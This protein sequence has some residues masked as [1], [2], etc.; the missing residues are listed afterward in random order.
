M[1]VE[2]AFPISSFQT[3][4][5]KVP[6]K[7]KNFLQVGSRVTAPLGHR[8]VRGIVTKLSKKTLYK[9]QIKCI[10]E[11]IDEAPVISAEIW[12]LI[13]W[14][15]KYYFTPKGQVAKAVLP[16]NLSMMYSPSKN[17]Y[18][19]SRKVI[20][21][22]IIF[23]LKQTAPKQYIIQQIIW[24]SQIP[25]R[26]ASL[27]NKISNPLNTC[28]ILEDK[29]FVKLF[30]KNYF[31]DI[32]G[33]SFPPIKK[34]IYFNSAQRDCIEKI[35]SSISENKY[36]PFLLHGV[37]GSGKTEIYIEVVHQCLQS[38]KSA[39]IL[40]P[41]ISLTPQIAGR[42]KAVFGDKVALWHS[43][44][45]QAQ[46]SWT[47]KQ[48]SLGAYK[49]VIGAR[50]AVFTPLKNIGLI[51]IDEEQESSFRQDAPAPR[52][53]ARDVALMRGSIENSIVIL[54][55]AT[56]SLES[57]YNYINKKLTYLYLPERFGNAKY[58]QVNVVNMV[59]DQE[60]SG[61]YGLI[62]S[63]LLQ[64]KIEDRLKKNEQIIL[65]H[66]RRGYSPV[67]RCYDCG[68]IVLCPNCKVSLTYHIQ[69]SK[70]RC[71]FCGHVEIEKRELCNFCDSNKL[72]YSGAGTQRVEL[73]LQETFP[74][75]KICRLD[76]DTAKDGKKITSILEKFSDGKIDILIGTQMIAKGLDF[77]NATLVGIINAD[78]GLHIPDFRTGERIFQLIYQASGRAGRRNKPGEV[79]IQTYMPENPVIKNVAKLNL[80]EYYNIALNEREELN[81]PP[82]SWIAK[83]EISGP[84]LNSVEKL[85]G[86]ISKSLK[87]KYIGLDIL[88]PSPCYL[89]KLKNLYRFQILFKSLKKEDIN[90]KKLNSFIHYN[91][92][93]T[94]TRFRL[95]KNKISIHVDP[96]SLL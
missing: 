29:G 90:G 19:C 76:I 30:E 25:V 55:S 93:H 32:K 95:G 21:E 67:I 51:V 24:N 78:L 81:Y 72:K 39:I 85:S 71:H 33:F 8:N 3:F 23:K 27:K 44:L 34:H 61:K 74:N 10:T 11:I 65:L 73:L 47:W 58:P 49:V 84:I 31:P 70:L 82:F 42:F 6:S 7:F 88:G 45:S 77:P 75:S 17:W 28:R 2:V 48:I 91:F 79:I 92:I 80:V 64:D 37:T 40:L 36:S 89:A 35:V 86:R 63:G 18:V 22:K 15:S 54:S 9:G 60:D 50:S 52:Y 43:K 4:S 57:Y 69:D 56:P 26:V 46:R 38:G 5:Y 41:E 1:F 14:M 62:L 20:D 94:H 87:R 66:N 53:H 83:I 96:Q 13:E 12:S 59:A 16:G 68:E